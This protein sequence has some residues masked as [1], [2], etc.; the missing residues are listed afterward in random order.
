[1]KNQR[2]FFIVSLIFL[3]LLVSLSAVSADDMDTIADGEVSGDVDVVTTNP[4]DTSG[5]LSYEIPEDVKDVDY[6]GLYVNVYAG[7]ASSDRGCESNISMTSNGETEQ[8]ASERLVFTDVA[9][10]GDGTVYPINDHTTKCYSDYHMVYNITDK[11][12]GKTG[13]ITFNVVDSEIEDFVF[14]GRIKLIGLVFAYN[15]GDNDK[16]SYWVNTGQSWTKESKSTTFNVGTIE[17]EITKATIDNVVLSSGDGLYTFNDNE[18]DGAI[19]HVSGNYYQYNKFDVADKLV[20]GPNIL[21]FAYAGT[22]AYGSI[23]NVLSVLE[24]KSDI[25]SVNPTLS[26]EYTSG[27]GACY[28]GTNNTLKLNL[29]NN[30]NV[31]TVYAVDFYVDGVKVGSYE[32]EVPVGENGVLFMTDDTI[33]PVTENTVNGADN[34]KVNYTAIISDKST[35]KV[36][37]ESSVLVPVL[38]NGNLGKDLAYP[39]ESISSFNYIT[40]N[41]GVIIDTKDDSTYLGS[42]DTIRTDVWA[43]DLAANADVVNAYLYVAYNWD[44]TNGALPVWTTTFNN[45]EIIPVAS[46]RDQSNLGT[47]GRYGY[48]LVVYDVSDLVNKNGD[49]TFVLN[50]ETGM[51]AVYPSTFVVFYNVTDSDTITTVYMYNGADLLANSNNLAGRIAAA[52]SVLDISLAEILLDAKL[53]VFAAGAQAGEGNLI[54]NGLSYNDVWNGTSK[55]TDEYIVDLTDSIAPSNNVSFVATGSTILALQ[56]FIVVKN[57]YVKATSIVASPL[58]TVAKTYKNLVITLKDASGALLKNTKVTVFVNGKTSTV[59][60]NAKGEATIKTNC[61]AAGTYYYSL[62]FAG[63]TAYKSAFKTV[64]VTVKKQAVKATFAKATLKVKKAKK[65]KFTLKDASGKALSGKKI[66]IT[67]NKKTFTAKTNSKGIAYI[68]V[69]VTKKGK[70]TATAKFAGDS[71]YKAITKKAKFT[72][73]K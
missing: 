19:E 17:N 38:Y 64:K 63:S 13:A 41:G 10:T 32:L 47:Y 8:I 42:A 5:E 7:S 48:G 71:A 56:Q 28:A 6:A 67:V 25:L 40:V 9:S 66:T 51:T 39:A 14:D 36:L 68:K 45:V 27:G 62:W 37:N 20:S 46:Y 70:F 2:K 53:H 21:T 55:T 4:W 58:T 54:V 31:N 50:K 16:V 33:R 30:G 29:T 1:M 59:T 72:V 65:V 24:I 69:K 11:L 35:G 3:C 43:L 18:I 49:N 12:Q 60:T 44:K 61:A 57:A 15:D 22:S 73:K 26:T 34:A 23:K 52:N